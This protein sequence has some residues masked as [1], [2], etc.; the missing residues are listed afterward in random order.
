MGYGQPGKKAVISSYS[1]L[2]RLSS[3]ISEVHFR[4]FLNSKMLFEVLEKCQNLEKISLSK[5]AHS[6]CHNSVLEKVNKSG[7]KLI[8]SDVKGRPNMVV[9]CWGGRS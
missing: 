6:R 3:S 8:I 9:R 5:S 2:N 4:K 1:D 7:M